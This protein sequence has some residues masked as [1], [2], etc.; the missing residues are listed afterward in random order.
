M[1]PMRPIA[2]AIA[3]ASALLAI[4]RGAY[5]DPTNYQ[6][7]VI[8]ER[9]L[10]MGGAQTAAVNDPMANLYN[11]AAMVFT[12]STMVS[13]SKCL[14]SLDSRKVQDGFIPFS[15]YASSGAG[16]DAITLEHR[17]DLTLPSTLALSTKFGPRLPGGGSQRHAIGVAILVPNQDKFTL[18][19]TW[20][21]PEGVRD[22]ETYSLSESFT[23]V[24]MGLSYAFRAVERLGI[25]ASVFLST[26]SYER[27]LVQSRYASLDQCYGNLLNCGFMEFRDSALSINTVALLFRVGA[28]WAPQRNWRFGLTISAPSIL[29]PDLKLYST[30]GSLSQTLGTAMVEGAEDNPAYNDRVE[31]HHDTY[32]LKVAVQ[33]P[34]SFRAGAAYLWNRAFTADFDVSLYLPTHYRRIAGDPV[35]ARYCP[36]GEEACN[37]PVDPIVNEEASSE[38]YDAGIMKSI[39]RRAVVNFN[40]GWELIIKDMWTIRNGVFTDFSSAPPVV[41][42]YYPQ[43]TR[44]NRYGAGVAFGFRAKGY[45]ISVGVTGSLG[46]GYASVY[47]P[48]QAYYAW[49]PAPTTERS[50]YVFIAGIQAAAVKGSKTVVKKAEEKIK[51][52]K[53]A[54][55]EAAPEEGTEDDQDA[56]EDDED[57]AEEDG[58]KT[59]DTAQEPG[60]T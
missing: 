46:S 27:N 41:E 44:V 45:D 37:D 25:G 36:E 21:A 52:K 32:K 10:G 58:A 31:Y 8:G 12:T 17:N 6:R 50:L 3:V 49:Q 20:R 24:W 5:A 48:H 47:D 13:A 54:E 9:A 2:A 29:I 55:K 38:W 4:G 53:E 40:L 57:G 26:T 22:S 30:K 59:A 23:Q 16:A 35:R 42:S 33:E 7:Y 19:G 39:E 18:R 60:E 56:D 34:M 15:S 1:K 14:Y 51:E 43:Q 28:L 11:P